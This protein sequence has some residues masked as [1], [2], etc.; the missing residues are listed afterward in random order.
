MVKLAIEGTGGSEIIYEV[1][2]SSVSIGASSDNDIVI[3]SP[4][5]APK[6]LVIQRNGDVYTFIGQKRQV[7]V[8]NGERRSRGVL[9]VGDRFRLGTANLIFKGS[10]D[11]ETEVVFADDLGGK[12]EEKV[13]A[14]DRQAV[15]SE[16]GKMRAEVVLYSEPHRLGEARG[17]MVNVFQGRVRSDLVPGLRGFLAE[18]FSGREAMVARLD[19]EGL[20][21]PIVSQWAGDLPRLPGR[22][23]REL[24][25]GNRYAMLRMGSRQFLIYPV[26]QGSVGSKA[27][28]VVETTEDFEDDDELILAE[29]ARF[30]TV[31]WDRVEASELIFGSWEK[32]AREVL[33]ARLPGTSQAVRLLRDGLIYSARTQNPILMCGRHGIGRMTLASLCASLNPSGPLDVQ[34]IQCQENGDEAFRT[35][36]FGPGSDLINPAEA[37]EGCMLVLR[38]IHLLSLVVQRE[39]AAT[40]GSDL[41]TGW[42][43]RVRWSGTTEEDPMVLLNEGRLDPALYSHFRHHVIRVPSLQSR[44]ED[45][46]LMVIRLLDMI[47][48]EQGKVI[49]GIELD[50]LNSLLTHQFEGQM[51]EMVGE[52]RRL[53]SATPS[54]DMIRGV[55]PALPLMSGG[56]EDIEGQ[57]AAALLGLDDL[58]VVIPSIERLVIDRV[59]ARTKGNQS[60]AARTLNLSRGA[61]IS[62]MKDYEI[63]DYRYL[64]RG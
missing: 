46:P 1:A 6:H 38:D 36:F 2:K 64:R 26:A 60:K 48:S 63:P 53:I 42:G 55:V 39:V 30:M 18:V 3:R 7:A 41:G 20:L 57:S 21:V 35:A 23:F 4:G 62:K 54:G 27:F 58:K 33:E 25:E 34:V 15:A 31:H 12:T 51:T 44:R 50:S 56:G 5:V 14:S 52:L 59:L 19:K 32:E 28:L 13:S 16:K 47:A 17:Q 11:D 43:P 24:V 8:L 61:L 9:K 29:L 45:L 37:F 22:T 40:M 49:R 10:G